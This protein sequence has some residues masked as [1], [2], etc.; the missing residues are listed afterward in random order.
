M[1]YIK[2]KYLSVTHMEL[3]EL[4]GCA[5][6]SLGKFL[7]KATQRLMSNMKFIKQKAKNQYGK[8]LVKM[9]K[10]TTLS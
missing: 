1:I 7:F 5:Y 9:H 10:T 4:E 2:G 8:H 6:C 3:F